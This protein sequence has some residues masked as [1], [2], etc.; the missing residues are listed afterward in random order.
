MSS[1][2]KPHLV[3][4]N[5]VDHVRAIFG[6]CNIASPLNHTNQT[7]LYQVF[8]YA[9]IS[10]PSVSLYIFISLFWLFGQRVYSVFVT[11]HSQR[12]RS[13]IMNMALPQPRAPPSLFPSSITTPSAT[14]I[15]LGS[16]HL[17]RISLL[18]SGMKAIR[19]LRPTPN[20]PPPKPGEALQRRV[21][22]HSQHVRGGGPV[23]DQE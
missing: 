6:N 15:H 12:V 23:S 20:P 8:T 7:R 1:F 18:P 14:S 19:I 5:W 13:F 9:T 11:R 21:F 10:A 2:F 3:C 4:T 17:L 16:S 22:L